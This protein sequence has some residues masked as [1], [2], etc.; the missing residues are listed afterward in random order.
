M[1]SARAIAAFLQTKRELQ[2]DGGTLIANPIAPSEE[3]PF[4]DIAGHIEKA[5]AEADRAG[6]TGKALT[7]WLLDR[8]VQ[9]TS[10]KSLLANVALVKS[11]ARLAAGIA[12]EL[13]RLQTQN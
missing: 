11:N 12:T 1:D 2:L 5:V 13:A 4:Q 7:P 6:V 3:I 9:L 8:I 10:G